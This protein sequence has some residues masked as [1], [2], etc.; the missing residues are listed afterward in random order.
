MPV[1]AV[2]DERCDGFTRRL[3][4][5]NNARSKKQTLIRNGRGRSKKKR[6]GSGGRR[7]GRGG[8]GGRGERGGSGGGGRGG[9]KEA[10]EVRVRGK[11]PLGG[12]ADGFYCLGIDGTCRGPLAT[13][14]AFDDLRGVWGHSSLHNTT[15]TTINTDR[16]MLTIWLKR[17][18][19]GRGGRRG[20]GEELTR[21]ARGIS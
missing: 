8:R 13:Q 20:A 3:L 14:S 6:G 15:L 16:R 4:P 2:E 21:P 7:R 11:G 5:N 12:E 1:V 10:G 17:R 19:S 9:R 18:A